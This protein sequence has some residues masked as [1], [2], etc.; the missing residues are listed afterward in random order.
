MILKNRLYERRP[1]SRDA[2]LFVIFCE[3]EK[4]EIQYFQY[5][6]E[7]SSKIKIL[8]VKREESDGTDPVNLFLK[9][10]KQI[11]C[12]VE[13]PDPQI[14]INDADQVWFVIDTDLW[15][16]K[17]VD[18][19]HQCS[20]YNNWSVAQ[21]NP[22]FEVWLYYHFFTIKPDTAEIS[23]YNSWKDFLNSKLPGGFDSRKHPVYIKEAI[24][25]AETIFTCDNDNSPEISTTE[26][27]RLAK[28]IYKLVGAE[29]D[30]AREIIL[31][32]NS[33]GNL[34]LPQ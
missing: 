1:P 4:R 9:A 21:S 25:N 18:L 20:N 6:E 12:S 17:I 15:G 8:T 10:K 2:R 33:S 5:F 34:P 23:Q 19:R 28:E 11:V 29:I 22:S 30:H 24:I 32:S 14:L 27:F 31:I 13:N 7:I 26:V 16:K 3:G